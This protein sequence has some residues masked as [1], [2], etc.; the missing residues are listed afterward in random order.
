MIESQPTQQT[1]KVCSPTCCKQGVRLQGLQRLRGLEP[2]AVGGFLLRT[3][4]VACLQ[5]VLPP[6]VA[7]SLESSLVLLPMPDLIARYRV[8]SDL[9]YVC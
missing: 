1:S 9:R 4:A 8:R 5:S 6:R 7:W 2:V 3:A